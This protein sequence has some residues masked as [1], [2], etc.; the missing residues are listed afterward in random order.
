MTSRYLYP[1]NTRKNSVGLI[2]EELL[3]K[4]IKHEIYILRFYKEIF[5]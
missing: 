5:K 1:F 4:I 2:V 3:L